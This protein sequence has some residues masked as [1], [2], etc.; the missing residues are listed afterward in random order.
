VEAV[1]RIWEL[2]PKYDKVDIFD[3]IGEVSVI[4][5]A[6]FSNNPPEVVKR[7]LNLSKCHVL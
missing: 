5:V 4:K 1:T 6:S 3:I 7:S 2:P